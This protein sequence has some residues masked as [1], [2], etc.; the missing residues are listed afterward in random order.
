[1]TGCP[2]DQYPSSD[3]VCSLSTPC[4]S[5][6]R[7]YWE[8]TG[9]ASREQC[10]SGNGRPSNPRDVCSPLGG[11]MWH[12][13]VSGQ[14]GRPCRPESAHIHVRIS[15]CFRHYHSVRKVAVA[16][17]H[18]PMVHRIWDGMTEY[19]LLFQ[20]WLTLADHYV[21]TANVDWEAT[22]KRAFN[23]RMNDD[24]DELSL[25]IVKVSLSC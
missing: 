8:I 7:S 19:L 22:S 12:V 24:D 20:L 16:F 18:Q 23:D 1:M 3:C 15:V 21:K 25:Q 17:L 13:M 9:L 11:R 2:P 10:R 6:L 5:T 14:I 4:S